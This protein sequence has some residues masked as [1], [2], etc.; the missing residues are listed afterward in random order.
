MERPE[1]AQRT[2]NFYQ[3]EDDTI[4]I[5]SGSTDPFNRMGADTQA[6]TFIL[7]ASITSSN[8]VEEVALDLS[9]TS[10]RVASNQCR[11]IKSD[12]SLEI[13]ITITRPASTGK[14]ISPA[15]FA[16]AKSLL[17][18]PHQKN[19]AEWTKR[20]GWYFQLMSENFVRFLMKKENVDQGGLETLRTTSLSQ[21]KNAEDAQTKLRELQKSPQPNIQEI[22]LHCSGLTELWINVWPLFMYWCHVYLI[23]SKILKEAEAVKNPYGK[24]SNPKLIKQQIAQ[25]ANCQEPKLMEPS[26]HHRYQEMQQNIADLIKR[27]E[28][29]VGDISWLAACRPGLIRGKH[30]TYFEQKTL[31]RPEPAVFSLGPWPRAREENES[32]LYA[33]KTAKKDLDEFQQARDYA[34]DQ[35]K[36]EGTEPAAKSADIPDCSGSYSA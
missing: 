35:L 2:D 33:S 17:T 19:M 29:H 15:G 5:I 30:E 22:E 24:T 7:E 11:T 34:S 18:L 32:S 3:I 10:N 9:G 13:T 21:V 27:L 31:Y 26:E 28:L 25:R 12:G 20:D 8:R 16:V 1:S 23:I 14:K 6:E 4:S 36:K